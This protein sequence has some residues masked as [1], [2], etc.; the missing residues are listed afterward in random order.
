M[1]GHGPRPLA[2]CS[3]TGART[4]FHIAPLQPSGTPPGGEFFSR[5]VANGKA[6]SAWIYVHVGAAGE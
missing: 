4:P 2:V 1:P 6:L 3:E 5:S